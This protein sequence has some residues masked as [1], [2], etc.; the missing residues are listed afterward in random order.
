MACHDDARGKLRDALQRLQP[1]APIVDGSGVE[2]RQIAVRQTVAAVQRSVGR[3]IY[4]DVAGRMA[5]RE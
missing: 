5:G 1:Y 3:D 2:I 4:G